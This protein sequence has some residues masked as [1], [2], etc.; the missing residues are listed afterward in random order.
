M[1]ASVVGYGVGDVGYGVVGDG[2]GEVC[3]GIF[4]SPFRW[5]IMLALPFALPYLKTSAL[6]S[7]L[8]WA[9]GLRL[10]EL[11]LATASGN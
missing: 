3:D 10:L 4:V 11:V 5:Q 7:E 8:T 2:V 6:L 9:L 1:T